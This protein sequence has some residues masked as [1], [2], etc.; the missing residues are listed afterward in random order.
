MFKIEEFNR[1]KYAVFPVNDILLLVIHGTI[2][3]P[4]AE[5]IISLH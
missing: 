4:E 3:L 2:D 5:D 1:D